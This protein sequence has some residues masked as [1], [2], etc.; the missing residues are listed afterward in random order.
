MIQHGINSEELEAGIDILLK[1]LLLGDLRVLQI[2]QAQGL[3]VPSEG[4]INNGLVYCFKGHNVKNRILTH[5]L[6]TR[7]ITA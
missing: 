3:Y 6:L 5:T 2:T 1:Q 7:Y 4:P